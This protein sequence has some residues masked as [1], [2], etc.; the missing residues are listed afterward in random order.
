M[1]DVEYRRV[2]SSSLLARV[3][4]PNCPGPTPVLLDIHGGG[5]TIGD[6]L[7]DAELNLSLAR[8]GIT[9]VAIDYRLAPNHPYPAQVEDTQAA[10]QWVVRGSDDLGVAGPIGIIGSSSGA[11]TAMMA[12]M[13]TDPGVPT[14]VVACWPP[15]DSHAR[16]E[17][18][19]RAGRELLVTRTQGYFQSEQL[20]RE[21][22][23]RSMLTRKA[24]SCLPPT[25]IIHGEADEEVP[26][27]LSR[28][29]AKSYSAA[30]G[31]VEV[32]TFP[33][34]PHLFMLKPGR[35]TDRALQITRSFIARQLQL[36]SEDSA[37]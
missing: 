31:Q 6:R 13:Q 10:L 36:L 16:Y 15:L 23:P 12:A 32:H 19:R 21:A 7:S 26:V 18:A 27:S 14:Y 3:Y 24:F 9:V 34:M 2:G 37:D 30:G 25:L 33:D 8:S 20:I 1:R 29:F 35:Q 5:W 22:N 28:E 11:H 4:Q 17:H